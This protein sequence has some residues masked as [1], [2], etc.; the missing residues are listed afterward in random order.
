[1]HVFTLHHDVIRMHLKNLPSAPIKKT[2][3]YPYP[4]LTI[5]SLPVDG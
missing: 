5:G 4:F 3:A 2:T 1:M